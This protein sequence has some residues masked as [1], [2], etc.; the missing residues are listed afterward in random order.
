MGFRDRTHHGLRWFSFALSLTLTWSASCELVLAQTAALVPNASQQFFNAQGQPLANGSVYFF[1]PNTTTPKT[2]WSDQNQTNA[3]SQPVTL[4][5]GGFPQNGGSSNVGIFGQ[6]NYREQVFDSSSNLIFDGFTSAYGSA[7]PTG[8][9]GT[10][11][12]PVGSVMAFSG[13]VIPTNWQL[14]YGQALSRTT[15]SQLLTALTIS[16]T[17]G[18]CT[19]SSTTISGF[20]STAQIPVGSHIESTCLPTGDT[21]ASIVNATTIT[22]TTSATATGTFTITDFPWGNG[23]G[24]TTFNVPDLRGRVVAGPDAMGGAAASRLTSPFYG[25]SAAT[26]GVA[27]GAQS[28]SAI[29]T[30][31]QA[32]L[33]ALNFPVSG[34]TLTN[35]AMIGN[36]T[37]NNSGST[38]LALGGVTNPNGNITSLTNLTSAVSVATQGS[39]ASGGSGTPAT[40][41]TFG[42]IQPTLTTNYIIKVAPNTTGAGGVV[43]LN[44]LFGDVLL[45]AGT[46][47]TLGI[48]GQTITINA[49]G[50]GSGSPGGLT[51]SIQLNSSGTFAGSNIANNA[52]AAT[53]ASGNVSETTALPTGITA[54][55]PSTSPCD[56]STLI[57][58]TA[59]VTACGGSGGGGAVTS[60]FGR[61]GAVVAA[62]GDYTFAQ[63]GSTPTTVGGYGITNA[64]ITTNNLS[65]LNSVPTARTNLGLGT[66]ALVNTGTSGATVPLLNASNTFGGTQTF[67]TFAAT[68][69]NVTTT[70]QIAGNTMTFPGVP[71]SLAWTVGLPVTPGHCV[72]FA[73]AGSGGAS[74]ALSDAGA[75]CGSGGGGGSS[76][77]NN[78]TFV[79]GVNYTPGVTTSL[80]LSSLPASQA[81]LYIY[82]DGVAQPAPSAWTVNLSTGVVTFTNPI[83]AQNTVYATWLST[84]LTSGTV[85]SVGVASANGFAGT[86]ANPT[87]TPSITLSTTI[88][89]ILQGNGTAISAASTTGS[90]SVVLAT[91]PTIASPTLSGIVAG[92]NTIPLSV[93]AQSTAN[94]MLGNWTASSANVAANSMPSCPDSAG[95]HLNYVSGTGITCGTGQ[96]NSIT[97][98]TGDV[99]ATGPGSVASTIANNAVTYAKFQQVAASSLVGNATGSL[100]NAEA[101]SIGAT[102]TFSGTALQTTALSGDVTSSANS[103]STTIASNAVTYAKLQQVTASRLLGNPTGSLANASEITL[104][105]T[106]AFSAGALQTSA[107]TGDVTASANSFSTVVGKI[108]TI[109]VKSGT[110]TDGQVLT[111]VAANSDWEPIAAPAGNVPTG[112]TTGQVLAKI[113]ATNFNTQWITVSGSGT[114]TS[115]T[116]GTGL[117]GGTITTTG[118]IS[119][120]V[121]VLASNGGT[122]N[123]SNTVHGV[124]VGAGASNLSV[125]AAGTA[126]QVLIS[127]GASA[128][129]SYGSKQLVRTVRRTVTSGAS[130]TATAADFLIAWDKAS[131]SAS[132]E[133]IPACASG[134]DGTMYVV[135][136]EKGDAGTNNITVT[137]ASGTILNTSSLV[138]N[139]NLS[140]ITLQCDGSQTNWIVE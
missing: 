29:T 123:T 61:T 110:P 72:Q 115:I 116:A 48:V 93:L 104:G 135:V 52:I 57:A 88:S 23:D 39:A 51:K 32:N 33:P 34:I 79:A 109:A 64:L 38:A 50:G 59:Y 20:T 139:V 62:S 74:G 30:L 37:N 111:Y 130:D 81:A 76:T 138:M 114:V 10:D 67:A 132:T 68:S 97:A 7:S 53:D 66:A 118:T 6:G 41:A 24:V 84:S 121:P 65:D 140:S 124:M 47:V 54:T 82:E 85:T 40:S 14:A 31:A 125:T 1:V 73:S 19:A 58:T 25:A 99:T 8:A 15:F 80:T 91:S 13:F 89:G 100:A 49:T 137:P 71:A 133:N 16:T 83:I 87:T 103:F 102:L 43:S 134:I 120:S 94:T 45:A 131:G 92:A 70:F 11:T 2:V 60:V 106:L 3:F 9:T 21:V 26:P 129:P 63:I 96:G 95:N 108:Q 35:G 90:G 18:N 128:D 46:N 107:I 55:T 4:D 69:G 27:G 78:Q 112:G 75:G 117:S 105:S 42:V 77:A 5:A 28:Q 56:N 101:V 22:V 122:G 98:L 86:V 127:G 44:G 136:D 119:L 36:W 126:G 12:A 113:D 17:T